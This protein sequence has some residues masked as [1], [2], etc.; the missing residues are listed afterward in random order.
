MINAPTCSEDFGARR[1]A[2]A[3]QQKGRESQEQKLITS[4]GH[5][6]RPMPWPLFPNTEAILAPF[7]GRKLPERG[8]MREE[9]AQVV[10]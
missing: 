2:T 8:D 1:H 3:R 7:L 5:A 10:K 6:A 4:V 9:T